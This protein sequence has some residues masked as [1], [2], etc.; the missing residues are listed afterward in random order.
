MKRIGFLSIIILIFLVASCAPSRASA[1]SPVV[2]K[3]IMENAAAPAA[4]LPPAGGEYSEQ[5][6]AVDT[7]I[8]E[9]ERIVIK[10]G[11]LSI[12]VAD[13][14]ETMAKISSMAEEMGGFVVTSEMYKTR[15]DQGVEVPEANITIRIPAA[16]MIEAMDRIKAMVKNPDI[17][18]LS[19]NVS[20]QD[21]TKEYTDLQSRLKNLENARQRLEKIM[22]EAVKTEDVL[23]VYNELTRV[24]EQIEVI[25]GQIKYYDESA[26]YSAITVNIRSLESIA[27]LTI[28]GWKP[29]GVAR[30][31]LQA[32]INMLKFLGSVTIWVVLFF[33]PLALI[34]LIPLY[35]LYRIIRHFV[36]KQKSAKASK[37]PKETSKKEE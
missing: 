26:A 12:V 30:N 32:L 3:V 11:S 6:I 18:I 4:P 13:P 19:E 34:L 21:V 37:E 16:R 35:I 27:P 29:Q 20:G 2:E 23:N 36:R 10:N 25:K 24:T 14:P 1:P 9:A 15:T 22:E 31:A 17:D 7:S 5:N 8:P 28:G 33:I